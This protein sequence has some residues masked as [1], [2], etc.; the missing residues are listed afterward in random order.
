MAI[1]GTALLSLCLIVGLIL[2]KLIGLMIGID[3]NVGGVGI[4]MLLLI[5]ANG[6]LQT[7][8][9]MPQ[10]SQRGVL[11]WSSMYIPIV[12]AMAASQDVRAAVSGGTV[13]IVAGVIVVLACFALVPVIS[14]IGQSSE[15]TSAT[16]DTVSEG[17]DT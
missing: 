13:A 14:R 10:P 6:L 4:A 8:G 15:D 7:R 12:V 11:F 5:L 3:A 2:G 16:S 9:L 17:D 1:Y